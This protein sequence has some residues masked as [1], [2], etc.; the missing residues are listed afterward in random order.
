MEGRGRESPMTTGRS[1]LSVLVVITCAGILGTVLPL[2]GIPFLYSALIG[3]GI[4]ILLVLSVGRSTRQVPLYVVIIIAIVM[5]LV[6]LVPLAVN[7]INHG[8]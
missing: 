1:F 8:L 4:G 2:F 5:L 7:I 6:L 3:F